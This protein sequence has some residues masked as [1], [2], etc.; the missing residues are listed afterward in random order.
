MKAAEDMGKAGDVSGL[1]KLFAARGYRMS[2]PACGIIASKYASAAGFKPPPGGAVA[3]NW[4]KFGEKMNPE[5]INAP[6]HPFGSM[7]GT[8]NHR[9]YG[10]N[11]GA[12]LST[13]DTGGHV[14]SI[15]PGTYD[16]KTGKVDVVDQYGYSHGKRNISDMDLRFAGAD[17]VAA[18]AAR[19]GGQAPGAGTTPPSGAGGG[20][21]EQ[22]NIHNFMRGLSFLETS[23][24]PRQ[25]AQS[26]SGNTG[27]FRQNATDAAQSKGAGLPDPRSGTYEEQL[28]ANW[29]YIQKFMPKAAAQIRAGNLEQAGRMLSG[30]WVGLPGGSQPQNAARMSQWHR[31]LQEGRDKADA[32][33]ASSAGGGSSPV[34]RDQIERAR[35]LLNRNQ[36]MKVEGSGKLS[37]DVKAPKGTSVGAQGKG[38]FKTVEIN[39]QTQMEPAK[40]GRSKTRTQTIKPGA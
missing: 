29:D 40:R 26:E 2:G 31:I 30:H 3:S 24:D 19:R 23:N 14:M 25:A 38:L 20:T 39:R 22:R 21:N 17:A 7:F 33:A 1:Q 32:A 16:P 13:G 10:G 12:P 15:V 18:A 11:V 5:D 28:K 34:S 37:V 36:G 35:D 4:H 6:G 8:Y 9:R 27:F